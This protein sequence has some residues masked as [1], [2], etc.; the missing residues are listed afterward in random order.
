MED[1]AFLR[2]GTGQSYGDPL[3]PRSPLVGELPRARVVETQ[4][5]DHDKLLIDELDVAMGTAFMP[6][7]PDA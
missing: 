4:V 1:A 2:E 6:I 5:V 7:A 3:F